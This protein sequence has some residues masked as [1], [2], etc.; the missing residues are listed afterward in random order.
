MNVNGMEIE[1]KFLIR[2]PS[3]DLLK[4][5]S[6]SEITQT[7]LA[8]EK[9]TTARVRKREGAENTVYTHTVK[10][11]IS[12]MRRIEDEREISGEEYLRLLLQADPERNVI[13][14]TRFCLDRDGHEFEIDVYPFWK[15]RAIMEIELS[16]E[17][18]SFTV[19]DEISVIR[20]VTSDRRY[21][22]A[23]LAKAIPED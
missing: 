20:E 5:C 16:F 7:Y 1:R 19:P 15:D 11:K 3:D 17:G 13:R 18:E 23:S 10:T 21:T 9:G 12:D 4:L 8:S 14:K 2:I 6:R 22:N